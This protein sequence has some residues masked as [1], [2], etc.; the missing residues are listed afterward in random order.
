MVLCVCRGLRCSD[1][2]KVIREGA[3]T[4]DAVGAACGA[5]TD[6]GS[7]RCAIEDLIEE[8]IE[9]LA[10]RVRLPLAASVASSAAA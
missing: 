7:C 2:K 6:C 8:H 9:D 1:V 3:E 4:L 10:D 5:G